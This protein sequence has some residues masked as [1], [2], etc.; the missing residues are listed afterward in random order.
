VS[1]DTWQPAPLK[2][3]FECALTR[4][5]E[6][7]VG[8][9]YETRLR[10]LSPKT[11]EAGEMRVN[12]QI[13]TL[14]LS[15]QAI[16]EACAVP[17]SPIVATTAEQLEKDAAYAAVLAAQ[18]DDLQDQLDQSRAEIEVLRKHPVADVADLTEILDARYARKAGRKPAGAAA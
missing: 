17:G 15:A 3:P 14:Y 10:Y 16:R 4:N 6:P 8:P 11:G 5:G 7:S 12:P 13:R 2:P 9:F 1:V 18:R